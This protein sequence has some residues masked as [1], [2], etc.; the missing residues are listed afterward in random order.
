MSKQK[1]LSVERRLRKEGKSK[2]KEYVTWVPD[3]LV[4]SSSSNKVQLYLHVVGIYNTAYYLYVFHTFYLNLV[5]NFCYP[6][7][8]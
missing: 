1:N 7:Y 3:S 2:E 4:P 5:S 6:F 8:L